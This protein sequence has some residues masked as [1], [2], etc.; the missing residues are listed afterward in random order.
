MKALKR[1]S[2]LALSLLMGISMIGCGS[3]SDDTIRI[4]AVGP[5]TG[6]SSNGGTDELEGKQLAVEILMQ[7]AASM[8]K[9]LYC[10]RKM[11]HRQL[12]SLLQQL[13]S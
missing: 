4:G 9:R 2:C 11:M 7:Q 5:Q 1:V 12:H 10:T 8:E 6:D 13:Q 3:K